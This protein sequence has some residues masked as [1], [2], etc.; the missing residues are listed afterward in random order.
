MS[1][2]L[3]FYGVYEKERAFAAHTLSQLLDVLEGHD[4]HLA[5]QDDASPSHLGQRLKDAF[6]S[7]VPT[8][9]IRLHRSLGYFGTFDRTMSFLHQATTWGERYDYV[10][11]VDP[12]IMLGTPRIRDLFAPGR[13]PP[14]GMVGP[15]LM[16][17]KR[18]LV[19]FAADLLPAGFRRRVRDSGIDRKWELRRFSPVFWSDIGRQSLLRGFRGRIAAGVFQVIAWDTVLAW[20]NA[21][22]LARPRTGT[23]LMLQ[24]DV[25]LSMMV[26]AAG[27]PLIDFEERLPGFR[28]E[29]FM[30]PSNTAEGVRR[31][32]VD[33]LHPLKDTE[34]A[35]RL[36]AD[37]DGAWLP[38]AETAGP[39]KPERGLAD[40]SQR[41]AVRA[42]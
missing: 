42:A 38:A 29:L 18:D 13:L 14:L 41:I 5:V 2:L 36:R 33:L 21:G 17:R 12:D 35:N 30:G 25:L 37:L 10:L 4:V 8:R 34:W 3:I 6:S 23:G 19:L 1:R 7:R 24:D 11:R 28:A 27:H 40:A 32:G 20:E 31:R 39:S 16:L 15:T 26:V 22:W 9:L